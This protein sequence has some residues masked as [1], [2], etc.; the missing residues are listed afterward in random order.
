MECSL[1]RNC[2]EIWSRMRTAKNE[3]LLVLQED[4]NDRCCDKE[5][6][7]GYEEMSYEEFTECKRLAEELEGLNV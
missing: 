4:Y 1:P 3:E 2:D 5:D 6:G 7:G